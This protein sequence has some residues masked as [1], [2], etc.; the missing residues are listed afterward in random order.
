[1]AD[2]TSVGFEQ[3]RYTV[4]YNSGA[5]DPNAYIYRTVFPL[6]TEDIIF[7]W[8]GYCTDS[9]TILNEVASRQNGVLTQKLSHAIDLMPSLAPGTA[10]FFKTDLATHITSM[11]YMSVTRG[12]AA[13]GGD[14]GMITSVNGIAF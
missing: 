4:I 6:R 9:G 14:D 13:Y 8:L 1:M 12:P 3:D 5:T 2:A 7:Y 11:S 10:P